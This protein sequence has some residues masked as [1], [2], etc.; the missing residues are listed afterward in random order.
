MCNFSHALYLCVFRIIPKQIKK[1]YFLKQNFEGVDRICR[2]LAIHI[3]SG[4]KNTTCHFFFYYFVQSLD[5]ADGKDPKTPHCS[6]AH[7][8]LT[9][10]LLLISKLSTKS[11]VF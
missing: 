3:T 5:K 2:K 10:Y 4:D 8:L 11:H 6:L 9:M 1:Q 7:M